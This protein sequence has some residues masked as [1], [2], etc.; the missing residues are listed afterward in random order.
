MGQ[1]PLVSVLMPA[2]NAEEFIQ[3]A[4]SSILNQDYQNIELLVLD[5]ASTDSTLSKIEAFEDERIRLFRNESNLG[6][7]QSCNRLFTIA[8]GDFITFQDADDTCAENRISVCVNYL[9]HDTSINFLTTGY[10][11]VSRSGKSISTH[12]HDVNYERYASTPSYLPTICCATAFVKA[13]LVDTVGG[14]NPFFQEIGG[15]DYFWIFELS[16]LGKGAHLSESLYNYRQHQNQTSVNHSNTNYLF[17]NEIL[18]HL[19]TN[20]SSN[21][22]VSEAG[23]ITLKKIDSEIKANPTE[24]WLKQS[25]HALNNIN[26]VGARKHWLQAVKTAKVGESKRVLKVGYSLFRRMLRKSLRKF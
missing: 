19:K 12:L 8:K 17:L 1:Q 6:Y 7:L 26:F 14:Y 21:Q 2:F 15:E 18:T 3:E 23:E 24:L 9:N 16:Q 4:I 10:S 11:K 13:N 22:D 25:E 5:D 20:Y